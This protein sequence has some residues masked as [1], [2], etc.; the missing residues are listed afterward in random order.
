MSYIPSDWTYKKNESGERIY[1]DHTLNIVQQNLKEISQLIDDVCTDAKIN[2]LYVQNNVNAKT[3]KDPT[4]QIVGMFVSKIVEG[5]GVVFPAGTARAII[6]TVVCKILSGLTTYLTTPGNPGESYN[7]IQGKVNDL[8]DSVEE[9]CFQLKLKLGDWLNDLEKEW[10]REYECQG[11]KFDQFKGKVKLADLADNPMYFPNSSEEDYILIRHDLNK[12]STY[13]SAATLIP[14]RWKIRRHRGFPPDTVS[15]LIEGWQVEY[16]KVYDH[17]TWNSWRNDPSFPQIPSHLRDSIEGPH[18]EIEKGDYSDRQR[19]LGWSEACKDYPWSSGERYDESRRF[20]GSRWMGSSGDNKLKLDDD[21]FNIEKG[22]SF[23]DLIED[24][25]RG[26]YNGYGDWVAKNSIPDEPSYYL[27]WSTKRPNESVEIVND[28]RVYTLMGNSACKDWAYDSNSIF[29][30][31]RAY[32]GIKLNH[33]TLV[34]EQGNYAPKQFCE[35]LFSDN[36]H[37]R[38]V[39][40]TGIASM[41]DVYHKWGLSFE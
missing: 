28:K 24:I 3:V 18:E 33:Y 2:I 38:V 7:K 16:Y 22:T 13:Q 14:L 15:N 39:G 34:D 20:N 29:T 19:F 25:L 6:G 17:N 11:Y 37:G 41:N 40:T 21:A 27:W 4:V 35:W 30:W 26:K 32:R 9:T 36:G 5:L 1:N 8:K 10:L 12:F 31:G 23:L